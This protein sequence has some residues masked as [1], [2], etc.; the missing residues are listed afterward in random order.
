MSE[1][2]NALLLKSRPRFWI[3]RKNVEQQDTCFNRNLCYAGTR[4]CNYFIDR[5]ICTFV[6]MLWLRPAGSVSTTRNNNLIVDGI[7]FI[8]VTHILSLSF[9]ILSR[10][11]TLESTSLHVPHFALS[12]FADVTYTY[13]NQYTTATRP[14][15]GGITGLFDFQVFPNLLGGRVRKKTP[16]IG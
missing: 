16:F 7:F 15:V 8:F 14:V 6:D 4:R 3:S 10:K 5:R 9:V 12:L 1:S 13:I 2:I 11:N